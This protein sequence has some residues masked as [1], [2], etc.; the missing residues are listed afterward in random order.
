MFGWQENDTSSSTSI[1]SLLMYSVQCTPLSRE[2]VLFGYATKS[3]ALVGQTPL[4]YTQMEKTLGN[5]FMS[6]AGK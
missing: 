5:F 6:V 4:A 2:N 1:A 3:L